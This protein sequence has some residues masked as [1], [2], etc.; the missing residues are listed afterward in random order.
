MKWFKHDADANM[1]AKLQ[2][3]LLDYG[4]EGYGLYWYCIELIAGNVGPENITFELEHD[5]RV[6]ARNT[7]STAQRV[8]EMMKKFSELGLFEMS[9][10]VI[11]CLKLAKRAD[12]YTAKLVKKQE[13]VEKKL[14]PPQENENQAETLTTAGVGESPTKTNKDPLD[15]IRLDKNRLDKNN[16][17]PTPAKP[18]FTDW[19]M[20]FS[21][22]ALNTL[23]ADNP[24]LKKPN[25]ES[26]AKDCRLMRERDNRDPEEMKTLWQWARANSFWK[27]NILSLGKFRDKFDLLFAQS[28]RPIAVAGEQYKSAQEKRADRNA[29]I[30]D[31]EKAMEW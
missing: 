10:G 3:I 21:Q 12:D 22:W 27:A 11:S 5:A 13:G 17:S 15:K 31:I 29:E 16:T 9:E 26:W 28:Q 19:D 7:C 25:L 1:D 6:I 14:N 8:E 20:R 2:E 18:K 23:Q 4:L 24:N 30:F